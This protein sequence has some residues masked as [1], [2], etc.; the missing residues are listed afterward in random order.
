METVALALAA[1]SSGIRGSIRAT[2]P[3]PRISHDPYGALYR[4]LVSVDGYSTHLYP[5]LIRD[6][7]THS[8]PSKS[9]IPP[10]VGAC[11]FGAKAAVFPWLR[12]TPLAFNSHS[13]K[14]A[15]PTVSGDISSAV[16]VMS[17]SYA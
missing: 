5:S 8:T 7:C 10:G 1:C 14:G 4:K 2:C 9:D 16:T 15:P 11:P 13:R 3:A 6:A 12:I 17:S